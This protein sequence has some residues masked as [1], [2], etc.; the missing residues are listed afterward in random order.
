MV[1]EG[2]A[3]VVDEPTPLIKQL[4]V[5][6]GLLKLAV[7]HKDKRL[8]NRVLGHLPALVKNNFE[9]QTIAEFTSKH[10]QSSMGLLL[11][12]HLFIM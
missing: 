12:I 11:C 2:E 6:A 5:H 1:V 4:E 8:V 9:A 10:C 3:M 7:S